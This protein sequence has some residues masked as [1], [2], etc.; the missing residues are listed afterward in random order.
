MTITH[1][2]ILKGIPVIIIIA[3]IM[4]YAYALSGNS[5]IVGLFAAV[6]E[7]IFEHL[8][9]SLWPM[10]IWWV[11][12]YIIHDQRISATNWFTATTVAMLFCPLFITAFYYTYTGA[13]GIHSLFLDISSLVIGVIIA[14]YLALHIYI[15]AR[16]GLKCLIIS[17]TILMIL[18]FFSIY[19]TLNPPH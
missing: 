4:H 10:L 12:G 14:Q 7:S 17:L 2:W 6:N 19:F 18:I 5:A 3:C 13:F 1:R 16:I 9:L 8:K 11:T 15:H